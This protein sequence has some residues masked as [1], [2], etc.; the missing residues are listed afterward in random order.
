[1]FTKHAKRLSVEII[2]T[3]RLRA[4]ENVF[5]VPETTRVNEHLSVEGSLRARGA[6]EFRAR[7]FSSA[8]ARGRRAAGGESA[9]DN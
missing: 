5:L 2:A 7:T 4:N 8:E 6:A 9:A 1:M 3:Y